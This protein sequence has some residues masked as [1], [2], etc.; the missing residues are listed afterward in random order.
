VAVALAVAT[1]TT[2]C[3]RSGATSAG[4]VRVVATTTVL[5]DVVGEVVKCAG[6]T[7]RSIMPVGADP[8]D[9]SASSADVTAMVKADLVV[10]NGLDL[11]EGLEDTLASAK[12]DGARVFEVA[13]KLDPLPFGDHD[14]EAGHSPEA[15]PSGEA[16]HH[17]HGSQDPHVWLDAARMATAARLVATE[18]GR[19]TKDPQ[20]FERCGNATAE[21][22]TS[23][24]AEIRRT[25]E[26]VPAERRVLI[27]DHE[28]FGYFAKAYG[29]QV[30]G[31]V[32]PGGST[33]ATPSSA[34]IAAL[35]GVIRE[36][37]VSVV[38]SN[39]ALST[40]LVDTVAKE[41]GTQVKVVQLFVESLGRPGSGAETYQGM[42]RT[43]ATRIA[44][45]LK[46]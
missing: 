2:G 9:F 35:V 7:T 30:A 1:A 38:F 6:G 21:Q 25:L 31:V 17:E 26:T 12:K 22:L 10:A 43:N 41:A 23:L 37:R 24:D 15:E 16:G 34:E 19:I 42:M 8:H 4:E 29:Y 18:L 3:D 28:A 45:A 13:P 5:G 11:E 32:I 27:T 33:L 36:K 39:A 20:T 14:G 44:D 40:T 46:G